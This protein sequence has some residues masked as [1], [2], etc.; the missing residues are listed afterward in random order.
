MLTCDYY[1]LLGGFQGVVMQSKREFWLV[2]L[3]GCC[4]ADAKA[5]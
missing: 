1:D 4:Y 2:A 5:F 3:L